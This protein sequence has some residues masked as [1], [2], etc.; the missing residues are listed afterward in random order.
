MG[1]GRA[2]NTKNRCRRKK[3]KKE[4]KILIEL[5]LGFLHRLVHA[6]HGFENM[7]LPIFLF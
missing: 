4:K 2:H 7:R 3:L 5:I 1:F 6:S